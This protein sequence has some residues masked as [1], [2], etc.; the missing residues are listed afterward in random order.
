ME[1]SFDA[2]YLR[3]L[4]EGDP[5]VERH[6]VAYFGE[7][8]HIKLRRKLRNADDVEDV[9]QETFARVLA[10]IRRSGVR[11]PER[12]GGFV[13]GVCENVL[14][15]RVRLVKR[16]PSASLP[17]PECSDERSGVDTELVRNE[18]VDLVRLVLDELP[19]SDAALLRDV[20]FLGTDRDE[21]CRRRGVER[22]YL[23][24]VLHRAKDRFRKHYHGRLARDARMLGRVH[25]TEEQRT[26]EAVD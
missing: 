26:T 4:A 6:F 18:L 21:I 9:R 13:H 20:F 10:T 15:E 5:Q 19:E 24:V 22:D 8:L 16:F 23:R 25:V 11:D 2:D 3:R 7:L 12:L 17:V 1:P 14:R